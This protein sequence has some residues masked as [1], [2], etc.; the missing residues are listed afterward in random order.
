[1]SA[2]APATIDNWRLMTARMSL[3]CDRQMTVDVEC[4]EHHSGC[5]DRALLLKAI[6]MARSIAGCAGFLILIHSRQRPER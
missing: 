3:P 2:P 6:S 1:M 5:Y 4:R